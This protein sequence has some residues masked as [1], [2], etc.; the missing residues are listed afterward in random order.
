MSASTDRTIKLWDLET[1]Q[2]IRDVGIHKD[3]A[4]TALF[5]PDG[6]RALTAGDE[7][8]IVLRS[9]ADGAILHVF[10]ATQHGGANKVALDQRRQT[11]RERP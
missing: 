8:E 6:K 3:M 5:L 7:G 4:R 11:G 9:I 2:L 10:S 1:K